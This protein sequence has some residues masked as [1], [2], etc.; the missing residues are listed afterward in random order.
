MVGPEDQK[1]WGHM[2]YL[3]IDLHESIEIEDAFC[4]E[5]LRNAFFRLFENLIIQYSPPVAGLLN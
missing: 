1:Q 5:N 4:G 3:A 2:N